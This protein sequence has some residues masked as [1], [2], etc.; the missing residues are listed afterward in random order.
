MEALH[1]D[2]V[3]MA[4]SVWTSLLKS[5]EGDR[6]VVIMEPVQKVA[7]VATVDDQVS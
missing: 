3:S 7:A 6:C 1:A 5:D 4:V 2:G